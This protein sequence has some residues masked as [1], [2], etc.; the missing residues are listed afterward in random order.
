MN[1]RLR[2]RIEDRVSETLDQ[3]D[4]KIG[5]NRPWD[6]FIHDSRVYS[7]VARGDLLKVCEDYVEGRW[8]CDRIDELVYRLLTGKLHDSLPC[9][10]TWLRALSPLL[11]PKGGSRSDARRVAEVHYNLGNDLFE[12]ML[13]PRMAYS[14]A[15]WAEASN[16]EEAQE[17][18]LEL[19]CRKIGLQPGMTV[20][21]IGGGWGSF[22]KYAAEHHGAHVVNITVSV[23]QR[24][25]ADERCMGL[26]VENRLQ[27]YRDVTGEYD[28][29]VSIGMFEHVG[30]TNYRSFLGKARSLLK[31]DGL[32]LLHTIGSS[33]RGQSTNPWIEKFI[34][35]GGYIP[36]VV[37]L[38]KALEGSFLIEDWHNFGAD[39]DR[40]LMAW[41]D[42][43][44]ANWPS[45]R[46]NY[47]PDFYLRWKLYLQGC[48]GSFRA[49]E[50]QLWQL[51]LSPSGVIG[52]YR[53][54]R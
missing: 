23:E 53:S 48:A 49:R 29:I 11:F 33:V 30:L 5:G 31:Q 37:Q 8:E 52:G 2:S 43:F 46:G 18:K 28:R 51:V 25:L 10:L 24:D 9:G 45:L 17:A 47:P 4:I 35:P 6:V 50:M 32:F 22:A 39:Y 40:T 36:A 14:C 27:D 26:T 44:E 3:V 1:A 15:Y 41:F 21:D 38:S 20:L 19:V 12:S 7:A 54:L 34:F 16:L 42:N 13:D